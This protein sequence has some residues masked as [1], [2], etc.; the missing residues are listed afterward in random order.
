MTTDQLRGG[1][2]YKLQRKLRFSRPLTLQPVHP[3]SVLGGGVGEHHVGVVEH[4]Q[5]IQSERVDLQLVQRKLR[6]CVEADVT[7]TGQGVGQLFGEAWRR[8]A[9]D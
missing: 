9:C 6:V 8:L 7:D 4:V 1:K 2:M 5:S 3:E